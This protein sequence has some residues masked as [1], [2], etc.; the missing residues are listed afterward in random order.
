MIKARWNM[1]MILSEFDF[2]D[3]DEADDVRAVAW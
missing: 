3:A 2:F 1:D